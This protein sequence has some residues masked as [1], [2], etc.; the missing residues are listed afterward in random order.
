AYRTGSFRAGFDATADRQQFLR[1]GERL[2]AAPSARRR[3]DSPHVTHS[4]QWLHQQASRRSHVRRH[5]GGFALDVLKY[6]HQGP[7]RAPPL[8]NRLWGRHRAGST[9][10]RWSC[11][12]RSSAKVPRYERSER[13]WTELGVGW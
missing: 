7:A 6:V 1:E 11:A 3:N 9:K 10:S 2:N 8:R 13:Y 12:W 4:L 5:R